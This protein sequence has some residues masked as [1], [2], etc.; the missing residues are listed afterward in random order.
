VFA[1]AAYVLA[2][3]QQNHR[4]KALLDETICPKRALARPAGCKSKNEL[5]KIMKSD[6]R[7]RLTPAAE[8]HLRLSLGL[9]L[10]SA[11]GG[12]FGCWGASGREQNANP[13]TL[14]NDS[15]AMQSGVTDEQIVD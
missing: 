11:V 13:A 10:L 3:R 5:K 14:A 1:A 12:R 2:R 7:A 6:C 9:T 15:A 4:Y 8:W